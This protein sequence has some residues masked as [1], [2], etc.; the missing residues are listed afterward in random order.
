[1]TLALQREFNSA[2]SS[3]YTRLGIA[4]FDLGAVK[5]SNVAYER[6][7]L[8]DKNNTTARVNMRWGLYRT[9][10]IPGATAVYQAVL[11][12]QKHSIVQ[13]NL[14]LAYLAMG[15]L[16]A[17][18]VTYAAAIAEYGTEEAERIGADNDLQELASSSKHAEQV[19][20]LLHRYWP[21]KP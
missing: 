4:F 9:G 12:R 1:M 7:L 6:A 17:A 16:A 5:K 13:F 8:L 18:D 3:D 21:K 14:G 10:D 15:D 19:R 20:Q 2:R 11:G